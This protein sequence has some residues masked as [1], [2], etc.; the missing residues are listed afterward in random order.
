MI[1]HGEAESE[2]EVHISSDIEGF[3]AAKVYGD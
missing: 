1:F 2:R 3:P